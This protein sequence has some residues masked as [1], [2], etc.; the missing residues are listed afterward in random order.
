MNKIITIHGPACGGKST[1]TQVLREKLPSYSYV[2]RP[3]IK[4]GLKPVGKKEALRLSKEA[5]Y[6][7][8]KE[9][10]HLNQ[11]IIVEEVNPESL[12]NKI[13]EDLFKTHN[14][15]IISFFM[16]CSIDTAIQRDHERNAK[17]IGEEKLRE[18][19]L[20]YTSPA[21]Y[22]IVI[23]TEKKGVDECIS[24]MLLHIYD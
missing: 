12:K 1:L 2:D 11:N 18:I 24:E 23:N 7:L 6:F 15:K 21:S 22:E 16:Y 4:R 13:G 10:L 14:Y 20:N 9:L 8:I 17:T 19:N 3:Y 5:S